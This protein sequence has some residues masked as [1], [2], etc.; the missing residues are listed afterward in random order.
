MKERRLQILLVQILDNK[1][2]I[3]DLIHTSAGRTNAAMLTALEA[4][5]LRQRQ[6]VTDH[7]KIP[8][9]CY[10]CAL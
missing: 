9:S 6:V 7:Y 4:D 2:E 5:R 10:A 3:A 1:A 8:I